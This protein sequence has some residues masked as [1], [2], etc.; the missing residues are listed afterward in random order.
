[1][2]GLFRIVRLG[3]RS[4]FVARSGEF[5]LHLTELPAIDGLDLLEDQPAAGFLD[6]VSRVSARIDPLPLSS[7]GSA[8]D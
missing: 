7:Q 6:R 2:Q 8:N 4:E 3:F 5:F 1:M